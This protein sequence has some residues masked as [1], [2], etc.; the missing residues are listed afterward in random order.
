MAETKTFYDGNGNKCVARIRKGTLENY[1]EDDFF[2]GCYEGEVVCRDDEGN[3]LYREIGDFE[4][5]FLTRGKNIYLGKH[6]YHP[7]HRNKP[8]APILSEFA[9]FAYNNIEGIDRAE[10]EGIFQ[11][12]KSYLADGKILHGR[13][14]IGFYGVDGARLYE[15]S[16]DYNNESLVKG[17]IVLHNR[18]RYHFD[19]SKERGDRFAER[20]RESVCRLAKMMGLGRRDSFGLAN[21]ICEEAEMRLYGFFLAEQQIMKM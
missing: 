2:K 8:E 10:K 12:Y 4:D 15:E 7:L 13:G 18:R 6:K 16:G 5:G 19:S 14:R 21:F 17:K 3:V 1:S 11:R 9:V 20:R